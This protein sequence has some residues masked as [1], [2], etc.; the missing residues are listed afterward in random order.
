MSVAA[1]ESRFKQTLGFKKIVII[2]S[3]PVNFIFILIALI[4]LGSSSFV[5]ASYVVSSISSLISSPPDNPTSIPWIN[6]RSD[7]QYSGRTWH[8]DKCWDYEHSY[9]F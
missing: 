1:R 3:K 6:N 5:I 7:C 8:D 4:I 2:E 9:M